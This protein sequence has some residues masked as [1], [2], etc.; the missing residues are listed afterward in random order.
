M[1]QPRWRLL[2]DGDLPG[3][4]NMARDVA[5]LEALNEG[6][7]P[8]TFR[9]YGW[10][11]PCLTLGRHQGVEAADLDFCREHGVD[12]VRRPTGGRALLHHLELTYSLIAPLGDDLLPR[13][14]QDVYRRI[15]EPLVDA[16]RHL[17]VEAELTPGEVNLQLPSPAS[18]VPCFQAPAGGEVVVG[19]R[20]L[21]GS[22]MRAHGNAIL[23]HGAI[24]LDWDS[25]LQAGTMGLADDR[26][27]RPTITTFAEQ[28]GSVPDRT[29]L[30]SALIE[31][32]ATAFGITFEASELTAAEATR[33]LTLEPG[34]RVR[35]GEVLHPPV[36][37]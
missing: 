26:F 30:E 34:F 13:H 27:L 4:R 24:L 32:F 12:V 10:A 20:K 25:K 1:T 23:Q 7:V 28:L 18:T 29:T 37:D 21:I 14:L 3:A 22:A 9:L 11:P 36:P 5:I 2:L 31:A 35:R 16:C 6:R 17:G 15:C 19:G 8:P 33:E